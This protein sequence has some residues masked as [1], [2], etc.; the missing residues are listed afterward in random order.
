MGA[1]ALIAFI[2][3]TIESIRLRQAAA[4]D[5]SHLVSVRAYGIAG[6][7]TDFGVGIDHMFRAFAGVAS[8]LMAAFAVV[9]VI[10]AVLAAGLFLIGRGIGRSAAWARYVGA[11]FAAAMAVM[12]ALAATGAPHRL[13]AAPLLTF[14]LGLY[15]LW[16]LIWRFGEAEALGQP[17]DA[18]APS[19]DV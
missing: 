7:L 3:L 15:A 1:P 17:D 18:S 13:I 16:A 2:F 6:L 4:P 11:A 5:G 12:S 8:W 10:G 14:A 9:M 19:A